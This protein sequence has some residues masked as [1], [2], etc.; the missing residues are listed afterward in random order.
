MNRQP[1]REIIHVL[2]LLLSGLGLCAV[3]GLEVSSILT[4]ASRN[5]L[6]SD[7]VSFV[8]P[9]FSASALTAMVLITCLSPK[10]QTSWETRFLFIF[11][12]AFFMPV[13]GIIGLVFAV[14]PGLRRANKTQDVPMH[15]NKIRVFSEVP[16]N[17]D[18]QFEYGVVSLENLL[19]SQDPD[20]RMRAVYAT[21]KLEDKAAIPLL[22]M[23]LGDPVDD[24]R[25]LAY[26]LIDRKEQRISERIENARKNLEANNPGINVRHLYRSIVKDYWELA[27]LGLVEGETLS[28]VLNKAS[29]YLEKGLLRY[30]KDRG[31][32]LQYAKLLLQLGKP[33][34]AFEEFKQA[35]N[36]GV[37]RQ[38][39]LLYYAEIAFLNRRFG[40]VKQY[41]KEIGLV[42]AQPQIHT[43]MRYW[44]K[45]ISIGS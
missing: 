8:L 14:I 19:R 40:E 26:A 1:A 42:K 21:L 2:K 35:E 13:I 44:Q 4:I 22:R 15:I 18:L 9:H 6:G 38:K 11:T 23:A 27:H 7:F 39:L 12:I 36:L 45:E 3:V 29:E 31:L 43:T 16:V 32:H 37:D 41:M 34:N 20:K 17:Q 28:Y 24:I 5:L 10:L 25:L 30:P 33:Q